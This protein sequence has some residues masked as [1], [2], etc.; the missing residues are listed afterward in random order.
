MFLPLILH[1]IIMWRFLPA[2]LAEGAAILTA[3]NVVMILAMLRTNSTL[4]WIGRDCAL[5]TAYTT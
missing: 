5:D 3:V 4:W 1:P 2:I